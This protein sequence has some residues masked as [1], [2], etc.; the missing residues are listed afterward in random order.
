[1]TAWV[2]PKAKPVM[3]GVR[4]GSRSV[5]R[6]HIGQDSMDVAKDA[7]INVGAAEGGPPGQMKVA[8]AMSHSIPQGGGF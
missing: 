4:R 8:S 1:M 2:M 7:K 5:G 3:S 6:G